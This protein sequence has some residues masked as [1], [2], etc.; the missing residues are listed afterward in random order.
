MTLSNTSSAPFR[1]YKNYI[2]LL[3]FVCFEQESGVK[4][5]AFGSN[6]E[7]RRPKD[8]L[9]PSRVDAPMAHL[10]ELFV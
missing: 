3:L 9:R 4:D 8:G 5:D 2:L 10:P 6:N 1:S 7:G